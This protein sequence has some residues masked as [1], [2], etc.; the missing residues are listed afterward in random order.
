MGCAR[1]SLC[2]VLCAVF[3]TQAAS[4]AYT[5]KKRYAGDGLLGSFASRFGPEEE[6]ENDGLY[7]ALNVIERKRKSISDSDDEPYAGAPYKRTLKKKWTAKKR[8][9]DQ[10]EEMRDAVEN[11]LLQELL[12]GGAQERDIITGQANR[13][14]LERIFGDDKRK[15]K[16]FLVAKKSRGLADDDIEDDTRLRHLL[17][18]SQPDFNNDDDDDEPEINDV[19]DDSDDEPSSDQMAKWMM[20]HYTKEM[21]DAIDEENEQD[22]G[23]DDDDDDDDDENEPTNTNVLDILDEI[24]DKALSKTFD[25]LQEAKQRGLS[26]KEDPSLMD[27][28]D[29][30]QLAYKAEKLHDAIE[31]YQNEDEDEDDDD[32]DDDDGDDYEEEI[33][34]RDDIEERKRLARKRNVMSNDLDELREGSCFTYYCNLSSFLLLS[35]SSTAGSNKSNWGTDFH[36]KVA[37]MK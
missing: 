5:F 6:P 27:E 7:R 8:S 22:E 29:M 34:N 10:D 9:D 36:L 37:F 24:E 23:S 35:F 3:V 20:S 4:Y 30:I 31:E 18:G 13:E 2:V 19:D 1:L 28:L 11:A 25:L 26:M 15:R 17:Q 33:A 14:E 16:R 32:D 12:T 21:A